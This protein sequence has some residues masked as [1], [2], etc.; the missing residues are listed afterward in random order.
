MNRSGDRNY[1]DQARLCD[2]RREMIDDK[3]FFEFEGILK[4]LPD[5]IQDRNAAIKSRVLIHNF[6]QMKTKYK[7]YSQKL[8]SPFI[9]WG[10]VFA[11]VAVIFVIFGG[12]E[13]KAAVFIS[14]EI[15]PSNSV[16][17]LAIV[18]ALFFWIYFFA[19]AVKV[20]REAAESIAGITKIITTGAYAKVR[21]PIYSADII[22]SWGI[23]L[24]L[25]NLRI[26][27]CVFWLNAVL[28]FW[29]KLEEGL[30]IEKFGNDYREYMKRVPMFI[31]RF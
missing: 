9:M 29:M 12:L 25:P 7:I 13:G 10:I 28:F 22:L 5:M 23:F 17:R 1:M 27:L 31:P 16:L 30:L 15:L 6:N 24:Y 20:H 11:G 18:P 19:G 4:K 21:H 2:I 26:L 8:A 14:A 3:D